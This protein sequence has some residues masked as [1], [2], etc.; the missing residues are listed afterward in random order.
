MRDAGYLALRYLAAAPGR[1]AVLVVGIAV[2]LFLP[3][4]T[5]LGTE[6]LEA[7]LLGRAERT[8]VIIGA[9]GNEFDLTLSALYFSSHIQHTIPYAARHDAAA[10]GSAVPL[11]VA[12]T[13][14]GSPLVA[15]DL[16]YLRLRGLSVAMGRTPALLGEVV[17]GAAVAEAFQL[18]PGDTV[19]SDL[20]NLYNL[21]GAYPA[22]LTVTGTLA[23]SGTP[24]DAAFFADIKT[25]WLLE[26]RLHGHAA[27]T[28]E[29]ALDPEAE[30]NLEA[31]AALLLFSELTA[32][33]R[34]Q[35]HYHGDIETLPISAVLVFPESVRRHDQ[36]LGDYALR[37]DLQAVQPAAVIHRILGVILRLR[38]ALSLYMA[39]VALSTA[40][41]LGLVVSLSLRLRRDELVL[42]ERI[43][44]SRGTIPA[45]IAA[46]LL[47][48]LL[49]AVLLAGVLTVAA[50]WGLQAALLP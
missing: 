46:E 22:L 7:E 37:D 41:F 34:A 21:A 15:T 19:R 50:L 16:D 8:P 3:L 36:L 45:M 49:G 44:C 31:T 27:V 17:A 13:V 23:P 33:N 35:F 32:D 48:V 39:V 29:T 25:G 20:T 1:T 4:F 9:P 11:H 6:R 5:V 18:S 26:G 47:L 43:G 24:D 12:S 28:A 14:S 40:T 42:M 38:A 30:G 10:Y 2:A